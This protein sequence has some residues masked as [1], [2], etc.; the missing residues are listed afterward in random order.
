MWLFFR[1]GILVLSSLLFLVSLWWFGI[2]FF[3]KARMG[4]I[5]VPGPWEQTQARFNG[6]IFP[7]SLLLGACI[8]L[9]SVV[10]LP[11]QI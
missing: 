11:V 5:T 8:A 4:E 2:G 3:A 10:N 1:R 7:F 6:G 9:H